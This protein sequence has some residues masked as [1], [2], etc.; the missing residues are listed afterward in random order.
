[1]ILAKPSADYTDYKELPAQ[2]INEIGVIC[3]I[4]G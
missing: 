2:L 3:V 4:C 1:M